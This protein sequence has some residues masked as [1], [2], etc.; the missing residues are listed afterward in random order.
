M[1]CLIAIRTESFFRNQ[2]QDL[3]L[4]ATSNRI[5][6]TGKGFHFF[7]GGYFYLGLGIM[8]LTFWIA[9]QHK[10]WIHFFMSIA[11]AILVFTSVFII[12][13]YFYANFKVI[14]CTACDGILRMSRNS[15]K[16]NLIL[17]T[18]LFF[19]A[20]PSIVLILKKIVLTRERGRQV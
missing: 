8:F 12:F 15:I 2:I 16:Y 9:N 4:W 14:E 13:S 10:K 11:I 17:S 3:F 18:S 1:G 5:L 20:I 7:S 19:A 6:F